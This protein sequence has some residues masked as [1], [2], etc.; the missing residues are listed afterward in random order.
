MK[1]SMEKMPEI[2]E[3]LC[4]K[5]DAE[6]DALAQEL[7]NRFLIWKFP[8]NFNPDGGVKFTPLSYQDYDKGAWLSGTN[9][10]D[11]S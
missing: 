10:L 6:N 4:R 1:E 5:R 7:T 8:K 3:E 9:I 11:A 2:M